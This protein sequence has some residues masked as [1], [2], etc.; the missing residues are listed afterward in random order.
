[1]T[2]GIPDS[3]MA[4]VVK[5]DGYNPNPEGGIH[6][7][8]MEPYLE[9]KEIAVPDLAAGQVLVGMAMAPINP[10]DLHFLKGEYGQPRRAGKP[11]GFE[12]V[13]TVIAAG[14]DPYAQSLIGTRVS[15]AATPDGTGTWA[16][17]AVAE[18]ML[19]IPQPDSVG[20]H[21]AAGFIVNPLTAAAMFEEA[22]AAGSPG[23]VLTAGASQVSKFI[24]ALARDSGL[25]SIC[26]VRR[27]VHNQV[28][29]DL[30]ATV[31]LNQTEDDFAA[32]LTSTMKERK[33]RFF[34]DAVA[35][36]T[37]TQVFNAM[38]K[39][40][41]WMIYGSLS[42]E[43]PPLPNTG[44]LIFRNKVIKGFWLSPWLSGAALDEK[45]A[46]FAEVQA[47]FSD[48]RWST[49][50]G[51]TVKLDSAVETLVEALADPRGKVFIQP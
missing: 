6:F 3:I 18:A 22:K 7:E 5:Q 19:C 29:T 32:E 35:D 28:L 41:T 12:G 11:A 4:L 37:S 26:I 39:D 20:D 1:M 38:G 34:I 10:S 30:G 24:V 16:T 31:I 15:F 44:E 21:D 43:T 46:V 8:T 51:A 49:E 45:L 27:D 50:V 48:G 13:G 47:R 40:S 25:D 2:S 23:I 9:F 36:A 42:P 14:E 17:H 33:P